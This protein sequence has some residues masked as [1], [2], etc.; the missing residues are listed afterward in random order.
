MMITHDLHIHLDSNLEQEL[1]LSA[2]IADQFPNGVPHVL[3]LGIT[4]APH[5]TIK[6]ND[7]LMLFEEL[8]SVA[9]LRHKFE[10]FVGESASLFYHMKTVPAAEEHGYSDLLLMQ[11][12]DSAVI[13]K[14]LIIRLVGQHAQAEFKSAC[15]GTGTRVFKF[16]T[17]QDHQVPHTKSTLFVRGVLD[18]SS[19]LMCNSMIRIHKDA[20]KSNA[21]QENKNIILGKKARAVSVPQLEIEANDVKCKHGAAVSKLNNDHLFY[22]HSR[23]IDQKLTKKMLI[24]AFLN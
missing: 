19:R 3:S 6:L 10:F 4:V 14:D 1:S 24:Q 23:G 12:Q 22:L 11:A 16:N 21:A 5:V 18:D 13:E 15:Y 17:L 8:S 9:L 20:Q 7:D 2:L